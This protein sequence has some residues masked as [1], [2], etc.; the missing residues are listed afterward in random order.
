LYR[1]KKNKVEGK[2]HPRTGYE[3]LEREYR[4]IPSLSLTSAVDGSG[5]LTPCPCRFTPRKIPDTHFT[6]GSVDPR[7]ALTG[8]EFLAP[9][10]DS[11]PG[12]FSP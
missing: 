7:A 6:G 3:G 11:T 2:I 10:W 1:Q 5:W 9:H 4:Y 8:A 12:P